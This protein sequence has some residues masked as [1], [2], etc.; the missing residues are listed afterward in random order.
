MTEQGTCAAAISSATFQPFADVVQHDL[1]A[2]L[3]REA[4]D[5]ENVIMAMRVVLDDAFAVEYLDQLLESEIAWRQLV[6]VA[7]GAGDLVAVFLGLDILFADERGGL[8]AGAGERRGL[9]GIGAVGHLESAGIGAVGELNEQVVD[10][11]GLAEFQIERLA[12][13]EMAGA[14]HDIDGGDAAGA[15]LLDGGITDI[16]R[17]EH[18]GVGLDRAGAV[19]AR[20]RADVAVRIDQAGHE[21][22]AGGVM[23]FGAGGNGHLADFADGEDFSSLDDEH[24]M[25]DGL[26]GDGDDLRARE[27]LGFFL[28]IQAGGQAEQQRH[29]KQG[30]KGHR[31]ASVGGAESAASRK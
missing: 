4:Q 25:R 10:G 1:E 5:G 30:A 6:G 11:T 2:Q 29:A 9:D 12:A 20:A 14:G 18:A 27:N 21:H 16:E 15:G 22:L 19:A 7:L 17:I 23:D 31:P 26:A 13:D 3:L 24:T 28:R 8:G